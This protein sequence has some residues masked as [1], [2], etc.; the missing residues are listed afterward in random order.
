MTISEGKKTT[1]G[2]RHAKMH[3]FPVICDNQNLF[4]MHDY[5]YSLLAKEV[6]Q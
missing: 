1:K 5:P 6:I 4:Y 2:A 3:D